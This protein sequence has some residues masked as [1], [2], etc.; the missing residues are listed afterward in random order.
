MKKIIVIG[1]VILAL[2]FLLNPG[3][4]YAGD[5]FWWGLGAGILA[6]PLLWGAPYSGG[7]HYYYGPPAYCYAPPA[8]YYGPPVYY[9]APRVYY[10]GG[11][12]SYHRPYY[13]RSWTSHYGRRY[14]SPRRW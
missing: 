6:A 9:Y 1:I 10:Y 8:Y 14:Y 12:Y 2:I 5:D 3:A 11:Y 13:H 4:S 7:V